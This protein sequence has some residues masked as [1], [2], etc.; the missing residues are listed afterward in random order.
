VKKS[1]PIASHKKA[2]P[3]GSLY[4]SLLSTMIDN[5]QKESAVK[6][7]KTKANKTKEAKKPKK[8]KEKK[9]PRHEVMPMIG[10]RVT[11]AEHDKIKKIAK[12]L[13]G[14]NISRLVK[15]AVFTCKTKAPA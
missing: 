8:A 2:G 1:K 14:G 15:H 5:L 7:T 12:S 3:A 6:K 4:Y 13:A 11:K 10:V 9:K